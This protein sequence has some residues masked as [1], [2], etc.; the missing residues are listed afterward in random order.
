MTRLLG[1]DEPIPYGLLL[2]ADEFVEVIDKYIF[3][4]EI[5]VY[6]EGGKI[7]ALYA[8]YKVDNDE[9]EIKNIAVD[10]DHQN[11]GIG[12]ALLNEATAR[13][14]EKGFKILSIGTGD[15]MMMQLHLYQKAGFEMDMIKKNFYLDNYPTPVYENGL[16]LKHM[17]MLK[18][19]LE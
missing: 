8:L 6:Q 2:L 12:K 10:A 17:V 15:A 11:K 18:K 7:I 13:A 1:K 9:A 19:K 16:R 14:K 5:Y 3:D 4:S